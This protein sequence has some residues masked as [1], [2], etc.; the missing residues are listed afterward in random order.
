M[1]LTRRDFIKK[2]QESDCDYLYSFDAETMSVKELHCTDDN[3]FY[4]QLLWEKDVKGARLAITLGPVIKFHSNK[5]PKKQRFKGSKKLLSLLDTKRFIVPPNETLSINSNEYVRL[6]G[7]VA[8]IIIPRLSLTD[9]GLTL[10]PTYI[11]PHWQGILQMTLV[12]NTDKDIE[13]KVG[14]SIGVIFVF[15]L[16][17]AVCNTAKSNFANNSHHYG[18]NWAG[19]LN[20]DKDPFPTKKQVFR[21]SSTKRIFSFIGNYKSWFLSGFS[22]FFVISSIFALGKLY[23]KYDEFN[24][25]LQKVKKEINTLPEINQKLI[26]SGQVTLDFENGET[27]VKEVIKINKSV[28]ANP[29]ILS[30]PDENSL[31]IAVRSTISEVSENKASEITIRA[32]RPHGNDIHSAKV[33]W[34]LIP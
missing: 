22:L 5:V 6:D 15:K 2:C 3:E 28:G 13:L 7:T 14:D 21:S 23:A 12:N 9:V 34:I 24:T 30:F 8:A 19:I 33:T 25:E 16:S 26:A 18:Q 20:H 31:K 17:S 29:V 27:Q 11:D 10:I 4:E 1:M 32:T